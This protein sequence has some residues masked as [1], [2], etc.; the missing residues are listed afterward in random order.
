MV[1]FNCYR[2]IKEEDGYSI[3]LYIDESLV[4]FAEDLFHSDNKN[5]EHFNIDLKKS[6]AKRFPG[7]KINTV[8]VMYRTLLISLFAY[9]SIGLAPYAVTASESTA[10]IPRTISEAV[11]FVKLGDKLWLISKKYR[12]TL[13]PIRKVYY[14]VKPGDSLSTIAITNNTTVEEIKKINNLTS[15]TLYA[16]QR[17]VLPVSNTSTQA[18]SSITYG[19]VNPFSALVTLHKNLAATPVAYNFSSATSQ[20]LPA[21]EEQIEFYINPNNFVNDPYGK[22]Q[23][24]V[25][26][27]TS[28]ITA[29]DLNYI[30]QGKGVL[31]GK[32]DIFLQASASYNVSPIYLVSHSLLETGDGNMALA[33]GILVNEIDGKSVPPKVAYNMFGIGAYDI[34]ANKYGSEYAYKQG[35]F[36]VDAAI[37]GGAKWISGQYINN[38]YY[39]QNTLYKMRWNPMNPGIHQYSTDVAW[40]Y[41]QTYNI[42]RLSDK[43]PSADLVF[44]IPKY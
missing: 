22:Y 35:W 1:L 39:N 19:A 26:N 36:S 21:T 6:L 10:S 32:G 40:A 41:N 38:V 29:A 5:K 25:L 44:D 2:L 28:G 13:N 8:K 18:N 16:N 17:I 4:E 23:F 42:K 9:N 3:I 31:E 43:L 11:H 14:I 7:I 33:K 15:D 27:Y 34:N 37:T 20:W 30:L 12:P 24:L